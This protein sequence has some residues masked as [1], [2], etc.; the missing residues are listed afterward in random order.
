MVVLNLRKV[1]LLKLGLGLCYHLRWEFPPLNL[2]PESCISRQNILNTL[3]CSRTGSQSTRNFTAVIPLSQPQT[4]LFSLHLP[5]N[6][7][8]GG[9]LA[10][11]IGEICC[12]GCL[13]LGAV[14]IDHH[15]VQRDTVTRLG[16]N[17]QRTLHTPSASASSPTQ[18]PEWKTRV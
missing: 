18:I 4:P 9:I 1:K 7:M 11:C 2:S 3:L 14:L 12:R 8:P 16:R 5:T 13:V 15:V 6:I 10:E 17:F